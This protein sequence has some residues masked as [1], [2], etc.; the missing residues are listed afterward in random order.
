MLADNNH[1]AKFDVMT[2]ICVTI[3]YETW[4]PIPQGKT[5]NW[6]KDVFEPT[7]RLLEVAKKVGIKLTFFVEMGEYFWLKQNAPDVARKMEQQWQEIISRSH[8]IQLHLHPS[9]LPEA[10]AKYTNGEW[11]WDWTKAK[12]HDYPGD[13]TE[14]IKK[15][16]KNMEEICLLYTSQ[17]PRD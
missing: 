17:S 8:D 16:K 1:E 4:H 9:W 7:V 5:I 11:S 10:G 2:Y 15:C 14:L 6:E 3:D 12:C 13:L